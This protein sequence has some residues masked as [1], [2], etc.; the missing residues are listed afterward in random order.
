MK[1]SDLKSGMVVETREGELYLVVGYFITKEDGHNLLT[2]YKENLLNNNHYYLDIVK[3]YEFKNK[4]NNNNA[5]SIRTLF[6][7]KHLTLLWERKEYKLAKREIDVL[8]ALRTLSYD[9]LVRD[10]N[11]ELY[12]CKEKPARQMYY[13]YKDELTRIDKDLFTFVKWGE[14]E[15]TKID[16]LL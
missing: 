9:F 10:E 1:K 8:K 12:A 7:K 15:P 2:N 6:N 5:A 13:W 3:V 11:G 14:E 4:I 16:D